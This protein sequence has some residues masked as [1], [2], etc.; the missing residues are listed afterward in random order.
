MGARVVVEP[1]Q[2]RF[3]LEP[4][5][6]VATVY[7]EDGYATLNHAGAAGGARHDQGFSLGYRRL[8]L[9]FEI[10]AR[11]AVALGWQPV[12]HPADWTLIRYVPD[13][14]VFDN[15]N[16]GSAEANGLT[17]GGAWT[18]DGVA[19]DAHTIRKTDREGPDRVVSIL[20]RYPPAEDARPI[21]ARKRTPKRQRRQPTA[22]GGAPSARSASAKSTKPRTS[23]DMRPGTLISHSDVEQLKRE[24][25]L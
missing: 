21:S 20:V 15:I 10:I 13:D 3:V 24:G 5:V 19:R 1:L 6:L 9:T 22:K 8:K 14:R 16:M 17:D 25:L 18:D 4:D 11:G 12:E 23:K 2:H 7:L